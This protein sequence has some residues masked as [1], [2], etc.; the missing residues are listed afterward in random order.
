MVEHEFFNA[1]GDIPYNMTND[2]MFRVILQENKEATK[3]LL[4]AVLRLKPEDIKTVV[5]E[6]PIKLGER[7]DAKDFYL[8]ISITLNNHT[9]INLEMQVVNKLNWT[10]RSLSY[11]SRNFADQNKG[12]DYIYAKPVIHIGFLDY[13]L[14]KDSPEF[15]TTYKLMNVKNHKIFNDKFFIGVVDLNRTD[16]ATDEDKEYHLDDWVRL[17]K[18][19]TWEELKMI[20]DKAPELL[21]ASKSMYEY[22]ADTDMRQRCIARMEY[23]NDMKRMEKLS[24]AVSFLE[25]EKEK[26]TSEKEKLTSEKE[27]LTSEKEKLTSEKEQLASK[28]ELL[29]EKLQHLEKILLDNGISVD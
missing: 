17:F 29:S 3:G 8:D 15:Y 5:I 21:E 26:L 16:L 14:F 7:V 10:D 2:Y 13:T 11:I 27:K 25:S 24:D 19:K 18:A 20:A 12:D 9:S 6:N 1:T 22:N 4:C 23:I 28:N